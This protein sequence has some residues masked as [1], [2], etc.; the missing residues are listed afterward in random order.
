M[1]DVFQ[2]IIPYLHDG[3]LALLSTCTA[4]R[5]HWG[6][7][8]NFDKYRFNY[9]KV[10]NFPYIGRMKHIHYTTNSRDLT[11]HAI[12]H[13]TEIIFQ[14][15]LPITRVPHGVVHIILGTEF[16]GPFPNNIVLP[17]TL[18]YIEFLCYFNQPVGELPDS[19][20]HVSFRGHFNESIDALPDSIK[21]IHIY[22]EFNRDISKLPKSLN[23]FRI[24]GREFTIHTDADRLNVIN[25]WHRRGQRRHDYYGRII[26]DSF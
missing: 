11:E 23:W 8:M 14:C 9:T 12:Q 10:K 24:H 19:V 17:K 21:T 20:E 3:G 4:F 18:K 25:M 13:I 1:E 16:N 2:I 7:L 6:Q 5:K 22:G 26:Y 15:N